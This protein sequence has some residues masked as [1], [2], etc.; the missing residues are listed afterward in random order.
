M[1]RSALAVVL[2]VMVEGCASAPSIQPARSSHSEFEGAFYSGQTQTVATGTPENEEYRVFRQGA[3]G[4]V[5]IQSVREDAENSATA[6]CDRQAKAMHSLRETVAKPPYLM[7]N[8]P[9][10]EIIFECVPKAPVSAPVASDEAK[11]KKLATLKSLLDN[12]ALTQDEFEKEKAKVL[13]Q[14]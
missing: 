4:F 9:R 2:I 14:P 10:I 5:S 1:R 7:G 13:S 12:G 11:Y 6:F 3:T 8:F